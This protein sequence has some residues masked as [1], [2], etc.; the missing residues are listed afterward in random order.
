MIPFGKSL[1]RDETGAAAVEFAIVAPVAVMII[2]GTI[3]VG[4]VMF[5]VNDL[6]ASLSTAAREWMIHP[7]AANSDVTEIFC[8]RAVMVDCDQ[9]TLTVTSQT[10]DGQDWRVVTAT[11]PFDSP[12]SNLLPFPDELT[13]AQHVPIYED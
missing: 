7:D 11:T 2:L 5:L 1:R 13:R 6:Q 8:G 3:E 12:L 9:T 10:V 4:R